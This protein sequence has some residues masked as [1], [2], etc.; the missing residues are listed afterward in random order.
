MPYDYG[1]FDS[2]VYDVLRG[3]EADRLV[4]SSTTSRGWKKYELTEEGLQLGGE[5]L[6]GLGPQASNYLK[7]LSAWVLSLSFAQLVSAVYKAYPDMKANSVF[8]G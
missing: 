2:S 7:Q 4:A 6:A 1:P 3:L 5:V 8:R